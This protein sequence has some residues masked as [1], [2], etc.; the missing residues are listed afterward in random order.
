MDKDEAYMATKEQAVDV[1][2]RTAISGS[3]PKGKGKDE[4]PKGKGKKGK[5][6]HVKGWG[7]AQDTEKAPPA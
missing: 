5:G 7:G 1:K 2:M 4:G 3:N 6:G